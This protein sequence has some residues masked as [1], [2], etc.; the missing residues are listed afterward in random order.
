LSVQTDIGTFELLKDEVRSAFS[1]PRSTL[2]YLEPVQKG[3]NP[4]WGYAFIGG[5]FGHGVGLSQT[6]SYR[7]SAL[8]W[9]SRRILNFYYPGTEI[10]ILS[11]RSN[12]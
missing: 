11:A 6:G 9:S 4:L 2:F 3:D 1:A 5:G 7:L 12:P 8:G 10:Q